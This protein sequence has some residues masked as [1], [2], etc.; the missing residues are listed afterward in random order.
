M[1]GRNKMLSVYQFGKKIGS[2][3]KDQLKKWIKD[4][5]KT[6]RELLEDELLHDYEQH[7]PLQ[8]IHTDLEKVMHTFSQEEIEKCG[9]ELGRPVGQVL[10]ETEKEDWYTLPDAKNRFLKAIVDELF[11]VVLGD[12]YENLIHSSIS[13]T[14]EETQ[15]LEQEKYK[16]WACLSLKVIQQKPIKEVYSLLIEL[17]DKVVISQILNEEIMSFG[18]VS[19]YEEAIEKMD[20]GEYPT[21]REQLAKMLFNELSFART[22]IIDDAMNE[23]HAGELDWKNWY[24]QYGNR[25]FSHSVESVE[26]QAANKIVWYKGLDLEKYDQFKIESK[27]DLHMHELLICNGAE[28]STFVGA[29]KLETLKIDEQHEP[30]QVITWKQSTITVDPG[31]LTNERYFILAVEQKDGELLREAVRENKLPDCPVYRLPFNMEYRELQTIS[32]PLCIDFGTTNTTAGVYLKKDYVEPMPEHSILIGNVKYEGYGNEKPS[33]GIN[34]ISYYNT[35]LGENRSLKEMKNTTIPTVVYV[36]CINT[37]TQEVLYQFG[38]DALA[39]IRQ[40]KEQHS[41]SPNAKKVGTL[42]YGLKRWMNS[43]EEMERLVDTNGNVTSVRRFDIVKAYIEYVISRARHQVKGN[44]KTLHFSAP[45]KMKA[46]FINEFSQMFRPDEG[47]KVLSDKETL[48]EGVAVLYDV[49]HSEVENRKNDDMF[50]GRALIIDCGGGTTDLAQCHYKVNRGLFGESILGITTNFENGNPN[51]GGNNLTYRIMQ[52]L[53]IKLASFYKESN[54]LTTEQPTVSEYLPSMDDAISRINQPSLSD[55]TQHM[56]EI[57]KLYEQLEKAYKNEDEF[58]PTKFKHYESAS[59]QVVE[60][61]RHNFYF[62]W[63]MAEDIKRQFF[64]QMNKVQFQFDG[65]D[66]KIEA[67]M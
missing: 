62:L 31:S 52:M 12:D 14:K 36:D 47:Y 67:Q 7:V 28:G 58:I 19:T 50:D 4:K 44:F 32:A 29:A 56:S 16:E 10:K 54:T 24:E 59:G 39:R 61:V 30:V 51:F 41:Q 11:Y 38:Y 65:Q 45:I 37:D 48:D 49:I 25:L 20:K 15:S 23:S 6:M 22:G 42:I 35:S 55:D 57:V 1:K 63:D 66:D 17:K 8:Q 18:S 43:L 40:V 13:N 2:D 64:S 9:Q 33:D 34:L 60:K 53:K 21:V 27:I 5:N 3:S 26:I 46:Q